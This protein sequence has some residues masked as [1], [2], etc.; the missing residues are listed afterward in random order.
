MIHVAVVEILIIEGFE[1]LDLPILV[2]SWGKNLPP[3][4]CWISF[5][6]MALKYGFNSF[7]I[8]PVFPKSSKPEQGSPHV[9]VEP[10]GR[11]NP[12]FA[13]FVK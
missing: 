6:K 7:S 13:V 3:N 4:N 10:L 9:L 2:F 11:S 1:N 5:I 8:G 12:N